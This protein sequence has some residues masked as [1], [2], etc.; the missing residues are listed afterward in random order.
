MQPDP[1]HL[2]WQVNQ[3]LRPAS[4]LIDRNFKVTASESDS[5]AG[6]AG[7]GLVDFI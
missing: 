5:P 2:V 6:Q 4:V 7:R 3:I 1:C